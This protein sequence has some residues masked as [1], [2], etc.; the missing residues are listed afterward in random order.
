MCPALSLQQPRGEQVR[1]L[2]IQPPVFK[3][4]CLM[5]NRRPD[6]KTDTGPEGRKPRR[7]GW[8]ETATAGGAASRGQEGLHG[9]TAG[10][11]TTGRSWSCGMQ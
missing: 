11:A 2:S 10:V 6:G 5:S 9:V 8:S 1:P 7:V 3:E 4:P